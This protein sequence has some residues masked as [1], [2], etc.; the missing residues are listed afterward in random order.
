MWNSE[1]NTSLRCAWQM[2]RGPEGLY[3]QH[4]QEHTQSDILDVVK[5]YTSLVPRSIFLYIEGR[6]IGHGNQ[7]QAEINVAGARQ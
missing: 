4:S 7:Y 5:G 3:R 1:A 6:K 2:E